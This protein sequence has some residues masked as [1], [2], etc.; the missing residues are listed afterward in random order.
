MPGRVFLA[1]DPSPGVRGALAQLQQALRDG[2]PRWLGEKWVRPELLHVTVRF[3]GAM[4]D[5]DV[6]RLLGALRA[7]ISEQRPFELALRGVRAMP[8]LRRAS[9][10]WAT[11]GGDAEVLR[12]LCA[13]VDG[14]VS[15]ATGIE[16]VPRALRPH[17]TLARARRPHR[18][19]RAAI[20]A[21]SAYLGSCGK[22]PD[23]IVSVRSL[24][25][26]ASTLGPAG[27]TYAPLGEVALRLPGLEGCD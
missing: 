20:D 6:S 21:A 3:I 27:P 14:A 5:S 13:T 18:L 25:L 24:T 2:D 22:D 23:R 17:V 4:D 10:L 8:D 19:D 16:P 26:Y 11:L 1:I 9:M 12:R 7:G 15:A